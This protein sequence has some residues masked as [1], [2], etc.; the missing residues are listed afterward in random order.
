[1]STGVGFLGAK[2]A[3]RT[4]PSPFAAHTSA[5]ASSV[6]LPDLDLGQTVGPGF[7]FRSSASALAAL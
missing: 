1:M 4:A 7:A 5:I 3:V 6:L 2:A